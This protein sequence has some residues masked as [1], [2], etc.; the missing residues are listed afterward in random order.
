M[1]SLPWRRNYSD[2]PLLF[3]FGLHQVAR[4]ERDQMDHKQAVTNILAKASRYREL[5]QW[6]S[7]LETVERVLA[8]TQELKQAAR[9]LAKA[10]EDHIRTR[11]REIWEENGRPTG[12]DQ[13]FWFQA[14][15]ELREAEELTKHAHD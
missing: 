3:D 5:T 9:A 14:E 8:L 7:D 2:I 13:E 1:D 4:M 6:I 11:A 10:D 15:R 12:R